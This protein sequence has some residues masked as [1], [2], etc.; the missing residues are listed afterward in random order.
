[1]ICNLIEFTDIRETF[2]DYKKTGLY[3]SGSRC[4]LKCKECFNENLKHSPTI[5]INP[6]QFVE[7]Y[8][9]KNQVIESVIFSGLNWFDKF[10]DLIQLVNCIRVK[11]DIDIVIYTGYKESEVLNEIDMLK[12]NKN[13]IVKFGRFI[14]NQEPIWDE[15]GGIYLA[16]KGQY[17]KKISL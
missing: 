8:I 1:M 17:F 16:N 5:K 3:V 4:D 11:S 14:P 10:E 12:E 6:I 13:I 9:I 2:V 15:L 7:D